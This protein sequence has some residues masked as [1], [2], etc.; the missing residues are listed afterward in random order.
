MS[1]DVS[2]KLRRVCLSISSWFCVPEQG[3]KDLEVLCRASAFMLPVNKFTNPPYKPKGILPDS[4]SVH[5]PKFH[6]VTVSH[7]VAPWRHPK[8]YPDEWLQ[9][10]NE[11]HTHYTVEMRYEDD[12]EFITH[13]DCFPR[14]YHHPTRDLALL[15]IETEPTATE[16]FEKIG[17][18]NKLKLAEEDTLPEEKFSEPIFFY[19]HQM[20]ASDSSSPSDTDSRLMIP[21][22]AKGQAF[23]RTAHQI[24][25]KTTP[26]LTDGMCGGPVMVVGNIGGQN[27][28]GKRNAVIGMVEG[29][30]PATHPN[31]SLQE[32]AVFVEAGDIRKFIGEV[33]DGKVV[34]IEGG[35]VQE[36]IAKDKD[37]SKMDIKKI[38]DGK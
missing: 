24:F 18:E 6:V 12:G 37:P 4:R 35:E 30:V 22:L 20:I 31:P 14:V 10:I 9:F 27:T 2:G 19:G 25:C 32:A 36:F 23:A 38:L 1:K 26:V 21:K 16:L 7:A 15:H 33:E 29:I 17:L 34:P 13:F 3:M 28:R 5:P 11:K 8:L